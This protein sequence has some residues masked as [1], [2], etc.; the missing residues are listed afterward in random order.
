MSDRMQS[1]KEKFLDRIE[2]DIA[3]RGI[4]RINVA[5]IGELVDIV[6]DLAEAEK[7]CKKAMYYHEVVKAMGGSTEYSEQPAYSG[8]YSGVIEPLR[9]A[10]QAAGPDERAKMRR[11]IR[12]IAGLN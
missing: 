5:E 1:L 7:D 11:E 2:T 9:K 8:D 6:K 12:A 4:E 3:E 10:I